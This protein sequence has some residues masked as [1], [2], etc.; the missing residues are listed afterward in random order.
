MAKKKFILQGF[1]AKT[2]K[3]ALADLFQV[4]DVQ[5]VIF[6]IAFV[7]SDGV[8]LIEAK[9]KEHAPRTTAFIGIRNDITSLQAAKLLLGLGITLYVVDTGSRRVIYHPKIYLVRGQQQ[10]R[11][12]IGSANLT[13]GGLNNNIEAGVVAECDMGDH[14]DRLL[15]ESIESG[16]DEQP[17][18]YPENILLI[19]TAAQLDQL[20]KKGLLVDEAATTPPR[21]AASGSSPADD[22]VPR[23]KL[24]VRPITAALAAAKKSATNATPVKKVPSR[25]TTAK[26]VAAVALAPAATGVAFERVWESKAL[27][28]RDL[29]VP[30]G[31]NT[32]K[33]GSINLDKGLLEKGID[34]RKYFRDEVFN[35]L[36]WT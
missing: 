29:N 17:P 3:D 28:K 13:P 14:A 30:D 22:S 2:H 36:N 7:N 15:V 19:T 25:K 20:H 4:A 5:R 34:Q 26:K 27:T 32:H 31:K 16:F 8:R 10:T 12:I 23:I 11:L 35:L 21:P 1:T 24:K 18:A 6:S 33:T 9:I